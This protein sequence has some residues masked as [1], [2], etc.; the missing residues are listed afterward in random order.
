ML[1]S[2][3]SRETLTISSYFYYGKPDSMTTVMFHCTTSMFIILPSFS[4]AEIVLVHVCHALAPIIAL[5]IDHWCAA[6]KA[7]KM[8]T[9]IQPKTQH[10]IS[11]A[12]LN[13]WLALMACYTNHQLEIWIFLFFL[14]RCYVHT[15][16]IP[17]TFIFIPHGIIVWLLKCG[18]VIGM[19]KNLNMFNDKSFF[20]LNI[21]IMV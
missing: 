2:L 17:F 6:N 12:K 19:G 1:A 8:A 18:R 7:I 15:I 10:V 13:W 21:C 11:L 16:H 14:W 9:I 20:P 4:S 5:D 3:S